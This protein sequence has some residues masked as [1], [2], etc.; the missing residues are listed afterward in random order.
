[1][2]LRWQNAHT[3]PG[4]HPQHH[5][6]SGMVAHADDL[7][8]EEVDTGRLRVQG[9]PQLNRTFEAQASLC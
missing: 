9:H 1:M 3:K 8:T 6:K 4:F 7:S 2:Q 5:V